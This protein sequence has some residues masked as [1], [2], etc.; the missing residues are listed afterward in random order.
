MLSLFVFLICASLISQRLHAQISV[1]KLQWSASSVALKKKE[2]SEMKIAKT[3]ATSF[4]AQQKAAENNRDWLACSQKASKNA[5]KHASLKGR[6]HLS[7]VKCTR[8]YFDK[9]NTDQGL[10]AA[11]VRIPTIS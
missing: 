8:L 3:L 10:E 7:W 6:I 9:K 5:A 1:E 4:L 2:Q 11:L